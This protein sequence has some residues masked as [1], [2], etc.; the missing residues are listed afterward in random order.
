MQKQ[1]IQYI[2]SLRGFAILLVVI[3]HVSLYSFNANPSFSFNSI[4]LTF[5]M[6]L[7]FFLSGFLFYKSDR[8]ATNGDY[9]SFLLNKFK[10]QIIPT[11]V[12]G[13]LF[14][15]MMN[16]SGPDMFFHQTKHGYWFTVVLFFFFFFYSSTSFIC[17]RLLGVKNDNTILL[18][19]ALVALFIS[20]VSHYCDLFDNHSGCKYV[21]W[22]SSLLSFNKWR[23]YIYFVFGVLVKKT[24]YQFRNLHGSVTM[25]LI[26]IFEIFLLVLRH[27]FGPTSPYC[28]YGGV[29]LILGFLGIIILVSVFSLHEDAVSKDYLAGRFLQYIGIRTLDIYLLHYFFVPRNLQQVGDWFA[30]FNNPILEFSTELVIAFMVIL[31]CLLVSIV[32]RS[33]DRLAKLLFGKIIE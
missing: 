6:P 19:V 8:F 3:H 13:T 26:V 5:R 17:R 2:D 30:S 33:S 24:G 23:Y 12:F 7:F 4:F 16:I 15:I 32:I 28:L 25:S 18:I 20:I 11:L 29:D 22:A 21:D 1:R 31:L 9:S 10:V 14:A 27:C